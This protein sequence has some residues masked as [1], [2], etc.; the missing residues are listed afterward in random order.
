MLCIANNSIKHQGVICIPQSSSITGALPSDY[1]LSYPGHSLEVVGGSC[2]SA[3]IQW[4][5]SIAPPKWAGKICD[6]FSAWN[7]SL[8]RKI[9]FFVWV[10]FLLLSITQITEKMQ[11]I[12]EIKWKWKLNYLTLENHMLGLYFMVEEH[13]F[14][15]LVIYVYIYIYICV[16]VCVCVCTY[17]Y[18]CMCNYI[19]IYFFFVGPKRE[20]NILK[21]VGPWR[22]FYFFRIYLFILFLHTCMFPAWCFYQRT[23]CFYQR[24]RPCL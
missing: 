1:L 6:V 11:S 3:E 12:N 14:L 4:V 17:I 18:V 2:P 15:K 23:W 8:K 10:G 20:R 16:C 7:G 21:W 24:T 9:L 5:F 19:Y 22:D 13:S